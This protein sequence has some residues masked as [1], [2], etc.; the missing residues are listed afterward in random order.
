MATIGV[1]RSGAVHRGASAEGI[2]RERAFED[3]RAV[4]GRSRISGGVVSAWHHH[5]TRHLYGFLVAGRI[6]FDYGPAGR[7]FGEL[8]V[9]DFFH[10]PPGLVHRGVN[11]D[12]REEAVVV[13][14]TVGQGPTVVNV[15]GPRSGARTRHYRRCGP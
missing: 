7:E 2:V 11:P 14:V 13:H 3:D 12:R 8:A 1:V 9:G 5:G 4:V 15:A 10:I 6:R